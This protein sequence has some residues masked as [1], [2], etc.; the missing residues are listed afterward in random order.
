MLLAL[1]ACGRDPADPAAA[2][3]IT[4]DAERRL[5]HASERE[6]LW[7]AATAAK[8]PRDALGAVVLGLEVDR[9][10]FLPLV[11]ALAKSDDPEVLATLAA[12]VDRERFGP[13]AEELAVKARC[14]DPRSAERWKGVDR[15]RGARILDGVV[16]E[17]VVDPPVDRMTAA[18]SR[19]LTLLWAS[20]AA[21]PTW[22]RPAQGDSARA[23]IDD[24]VAAGLPEPVA[25]GEVVEAVLF[26]LDPY[27]AAVWPADLVGQEQHFAGVT[28]GIGVELTGSGSTVQVLLPL[29]GGPAWTAGVHAGDVVAA[30]G[31]KPPAT[32]AEA[33]AA[34]A[35]EPGT[36][37]DLTVDRGG[38]AVSFRIPRA[39]V[40]TETVRG[41]RR[42]ADGWDVWA[43]P[44]VALLHV[45]EFRP[46]TDE[47]LDA[48]LPAETP[49]AVVLDLRAN[50]GGD[51]MAAVNVADRFVVDGPLAWL[52]GRTIAP[53]A[54]GP[55]GEA[56]WNVAVAGHPLEG[57]PVVVLVDG[58]TVS[59]AELVAGALRER[60]GA[61]LVGDRTF[62]KGLSQ[63]WRADPALQVGWKVTNGTWE[64]P[65]HAALEAPGGRP[66]GLAPDVAVPLSPTER[67]EVDAMRRRRELP[68]THPDGT[69][70]PDLGL[71][72]GSELPRLSDDPQLVEALRQAERLAT[73]RAAPAPSPGSAPAP[74]PPE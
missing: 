41:F 57:V 74:A 62:G 58:R 28:T 68:P 27:T 40:A 49:R 51:V 66:T 35:G 48:L 54:P 37:A 53:P 5:V 10:R 23:L 19:R 32:V 21:F 39:E 30:V 73:G 18:A 42:T 38:E 44:G 20:R 22:T 65:S 31:G 67:L 43:E 47:E 4:L 61:V 50:A 16:A 25:V 34:L 9:E 46:G 63:A 7:R 69:P 36:V 6:V 17:Y 13:R 56:P 14:A 26:A 15:A 33:A 71:D 1:L 59:S 45:T 24:A 8:T 60:A 64:L 52:G 29:V 72:A 3:A 11:D 70:V 55:N 12:K 2:R